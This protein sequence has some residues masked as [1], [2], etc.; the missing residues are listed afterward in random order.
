MPDHE[1]P[2]SAPTP[3]IVLVR[4]KADLFATFVVALTVG[5]IASQVAVIIWLG[6]H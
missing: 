6:T 5:A 3:R 1:K 2:V 4:R